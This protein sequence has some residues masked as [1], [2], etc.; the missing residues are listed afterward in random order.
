MEYTRAEPYTVLGAASG[1]LCL[2]LLILFDGS[3]N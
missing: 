2:Q 1:V 3:D